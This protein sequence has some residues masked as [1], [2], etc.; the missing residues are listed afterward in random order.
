VLRQIMSGKTEGIS[1]GRISATADLGS[2]QHNTG[3]RTLWVHPSV[4]VTVTVNSGDDG[5]LTACR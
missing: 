1:H 3:I 2:Q 4:I 5:G